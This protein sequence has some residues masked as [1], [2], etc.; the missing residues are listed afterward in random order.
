MKY[1]KETFWDKLFNRLPEQSANDALRILRAG[2]GIHDIDTFDVKL[3]AEQLV[4]TRRNLK[5]ALKAYRRHRGRSAFHAY[6][7]VFTDREGQMLRQ[8]AQNLASLYQDMR[9]DYRELNALLDQAIANDKG[10]GAW[11]FGGSHE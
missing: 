7:R 9:R 3:L 11:I 10:P 5:V 8:N 1:R 2:G 4:E 6:V